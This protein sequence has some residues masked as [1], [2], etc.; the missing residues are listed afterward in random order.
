MLKWGLYGHT[1]DQGLMPCAKRHWVA[2]VW[3][4]TFLLKTWDTGERESVLFIGTQFSQRRGRAPD[5]ATATL[6]P[7]RGQDGRGARDR[8]PRSSANLSIKPC[9]TLFSSPFTSNRASTGFWRAS[10]C[11]NVRCNYWTVRRSMVT[12]GE[13]RYIA[14]CGCGLWHRLED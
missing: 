7:A 6:E 5:R 1:A 3:E 8:R 11:R 13:D 14:S 9:T 12:D 10:M 2:S 4:Y